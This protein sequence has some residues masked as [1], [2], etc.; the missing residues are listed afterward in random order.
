MTA[1]TARITVCVVAV[2][3]LS[4]SLV[5]AQT[6]DGAQEKARS[7]GAKQNPPPAG[8][9]I[10]PFPPNP[11]VDKAKR[12]AEQRQREYEAALA[13][14]RGE[15]V[16]EPA[17]QPARAPQRTARRAPRQQTKY[18]LFGGYAALHNGTGDLNF[19]LGWAASIAGPFRPPYQLVGEVSGSYRSVNVG[20]STVAR[21]MVHTFTAGP[22]RSR[23]FANGLSAFGFLQGG[24]AVSHVSSFGIG[25]S[26]SGFAIVP[27]AGVDV[28]ILQRFTLRVGGDVPFVH[29]DGWWK[30]FRF[31][32][33]LLVK[34]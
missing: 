8:F 7:E 3:T 6:T 22:Q 21:A 1:P 34:R 30:G 10:P 32:T 15:E 12:E 2:L 16:P 24:L 20:S 18:D 31:T 11:R 9:E 13:R 19:P 17:G 26:S 27:G 4:T 5:C 28:P 14:S 29:D 33:G 23:R 25:S